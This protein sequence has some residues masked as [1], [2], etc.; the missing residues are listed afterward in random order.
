MDKTDEM[1]EVS[2]IQKYLSEDSATVF[3]ITWYE[4]A[5]KP[6]V[7]LEEYN[8]AE[9]QVFQGT[10]RF[11]LQIGGEKAFAS[12]LVDGSQSSTEIRAQGKDEVALKIYLD[13]LMESLKDALG[14]YESLP[15]EDRAKV[16]RALV[17][18]TCWDRMVRKILN[19]ESL[20]AVYYQVAH[21]REMFIKAT[22]GE[23]GAHPVALTTSAWL[24]RIESLPHEEPIPGNIA[25]ELAK[26]SVEWKRG[27]QE[28]IGRYI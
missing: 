3:R 26:K 25:T 12:V 4:I 21:G 20:G 5:S 23:S 2:Q 16:K 28:V 13:A 27:T 24:S 18:K 15:E 10:A 14:K 19:K 11:S 6:N 1:V 8:E 22:E 9:S 17:A 7:L